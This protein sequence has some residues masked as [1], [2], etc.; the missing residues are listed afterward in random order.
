MTENGMSKKPNGGTERK[1]IRDYS[2]DQRK[3]A[4]TATLSAIEPLLDDTLEILKG[5][6]QGDNLHSL[7]SEFLGL[8]YPKMPMGQY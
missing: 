1:T 7:L 5:L 3:D 2:E 6:T 8:P 4:E